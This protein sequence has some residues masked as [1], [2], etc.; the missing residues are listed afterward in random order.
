MRLFAQRRVLSSALPSP[1]LRRR[2]SNATSPISSEKLTIAPKNGS[3]NATIQID[4]HPRLSSDVCCSVFMKSSRVFARVEKGGGESVDDL[5]L[6][7]LAAD[8]GVFLEGTQ[9][10]M[11]V[12]YLVSANGVISFGEEGNECFVVE[13]EE[14][15]RA[16]GGE[17]AVSKLL[18]RGMAAGASKDVREALEDKL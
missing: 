4:G 16:A 12:D 3:T 7:L 14:Q 2:A 13:F 5:G 17:D 11:G 1:V 6:S 9:M 8:T 10:R 18:M 15:I